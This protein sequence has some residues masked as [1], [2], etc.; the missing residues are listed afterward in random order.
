M[1][2]GTAR[3]LLVPDSDTQGSLLK[4]PSALLPEHRFYRADMG[5]LSCA[6]PVGGGAVLASN[7][8]RSG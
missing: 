6:A 8:P 7:R 5:S 3:L 1:P 4:L 2:A